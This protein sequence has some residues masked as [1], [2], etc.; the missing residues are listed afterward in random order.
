MSGQQGISFPFKMVNNNACGWPHASLITND[1]APRLSLRNCIA[2]PFANG[3]KQNLCRIEA[4]H[5]RGLQDA[6]ER[7]PPA[8][9]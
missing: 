9:R 2:E 8:G 4:I 6:Q 7:H 3:A 1:A 5:A